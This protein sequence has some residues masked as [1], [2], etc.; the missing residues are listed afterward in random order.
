MADGGM[1]GK[2]GYQM[3]GEEIRHRAPAIELGE[4]GQ[5]PVG[6]IKDKVT[7]YGDVNDNVLRVYQACFGMK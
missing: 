2:E 3:L 1:T 5:T 4:F 7:V 6:R